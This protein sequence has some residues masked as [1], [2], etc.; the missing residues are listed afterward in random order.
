[1][2]VLDQCKKQE[3]FMSLSADPG[4]T[5]YRVVGIGGAEY[6]FSKKVDMLS[7]GHLQVRDFTME[8]GAMRYG[9]ALDGIVGLDFILET[10]AVID[11]MHLDIHQG[12][13]A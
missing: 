4:D 13:N 8:F 9:F 3:V 7:V 10:G 5:I 2:A 11:L 12:N 1:M 6:V